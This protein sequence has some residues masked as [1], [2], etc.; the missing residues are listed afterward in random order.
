MGMKLASANRHGLDHDR[1]FK[2][3]R[4][5]QMSQVDCGKRKD[6]TSGH[7]A[8]PGVLTLRLRSGQ[9][10]SKIAKVEAAS[11]VWAQE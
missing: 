2:F 10:P 7:G 11:F 4:Q 8:R 5:G 1:R 9:A 3:G 6:G